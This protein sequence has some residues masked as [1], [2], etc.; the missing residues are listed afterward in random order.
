MAVTVPDWADTLLDLI[1]VAWPNVDEDAYR[2]MADALRE[3]AEDLEDDGQLAN[4]HFERLLSS[5]QGESIDALNEHWAKVKSKHLK[6][7]SGAARTVAGG[8]DTAAGAIEGMKLAALVQ[9]GYL[10]AEAGIAISLIPVTGGLSALIGAASMRATQ[11]VIKRLIKECVEEAV[12]YVVAAMTEP[13]VAA[14]EGMA[15]DLVVQLGAVAIGLQDGVDL[16]Q[17]K[18]A[19][20][21]GFKEGVQS[22]KEAMNLASAGGG[23]GGS[24]GSGLKNLHIEHAEHTHASTQLNTVSAGIHGKTAGKLTKAKTAHGR[25]RGRDSIADAIDPIADKA[26]EALTKAAKNMGDHVGQTLPKAVKQISVDHKNTDDNLRDRFARQ[27]KGDHDSKRSGGGGGGGGGGN[28]NPPGGSGNGGSGYNPGGNR[29]TPAPPWH[30]SSAGNMRHHRTDPLDVSHLTPEQQRAALVQEARDLANQARK[31]DPENPNDPKH[32]IDL[33]K[34]HF[35]PGTNLLDGSCSGSLLHDGTVTSHS[36][37]T[38]GAGQKVPDLHPAM[39]SIYDDV[40]AQIEGEGRNPG[41]GHGKCAEANLV[42][43]R[44]RS[45]DPDG[46]SIKSADDVREAMKGSQVYSVQIGEQ[47]KPHPLGHGEYKPPCRSC[48]IAMDMAG[49]SAYTG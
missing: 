28:G 18:N 22:G 24:K 39:Q 30:G 49:V 9:L 3:F 43:D 16:D 6:D 7:I 25:T 33:A 8:L 13:A 44:L 29:I 41:A 36:S 35:P 26:L 23:G 34:T 32:Q 31:A 38:K 19:G 12:G 40:K 37:A 14:L 48:E 21:D 2:E 11:E 15:A 5:S 1:G 17:T 4:N 47:V 20:Q 10:A 46:T 27:R 42:S 45:L